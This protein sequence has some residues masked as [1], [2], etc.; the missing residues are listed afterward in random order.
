MLFF[1]FSISTKKKKFY[2]SDFRILLLAMIVFF[3]LVIL[4]DVVS[5]I[6]IE[7]FPKQFQVS[8][9]NKN[10]ISLRIILRIDIR[11]LS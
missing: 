4:I 3:L 7:Q 2:S 8:I 5:S 9:L 1:D 6:E 10:F 11:K